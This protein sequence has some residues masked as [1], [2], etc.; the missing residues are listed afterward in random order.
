[1]SKFNF[2]KNQ[3]YSKNDIYDIC[4]VT[5][6]K[7]K[8]NWNTGYTFYEEEGFIFVNIDSAGRTGHNYPNHFNENNDLVSLG[9]L[10]SHI[11]QPTIGKFKDKK[12][13][14][15]IFFRTDSNDPNFIYLGC[16]NADL[17]VESKPVQLTW[18]LDYETLYP[19]Q[20]E[21]KEGISTTITVNRYERNPLARQQCLDFYGYNCSVCNL[22]FEKTY[23]NIGKNFIH[24]HHLKLIS[25]IGKEYVIDP[26]EDLRPVCPNCHAMLHK[27]LKTPYTI[28]EL[29][30]LMKFN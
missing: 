14:K 7:Q 8:G 10:N 15:H 22:N 21:L 18:S 6:E 11:N 2:V 12:Y 9:K 3:S 19:E 28:E 29:K 25:E 5:P 13:I 4:Q 20:I 16:G 17:I 1:M 26:I 30:E 24:V 23:G 27:K